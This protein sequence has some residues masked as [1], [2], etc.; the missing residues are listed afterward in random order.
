MNKV[1][2]G[3]LGLAFGLLSLT[4]FSTNAALVEYRG[5]TTAVVNGVGR[6]LTLSL[7][8]DN[9]FPL[10]GPTLQH[11]YDNYP[12]SADIDRYYGYFA[13]YNSSLSLEG[14]AP[15]TGT[16]GDFNIWV[17][18]IDMV[19]GGYDTSTLRLVPEDVVTDWSQHTRFRFLEDSG[20]PFV[21]DSWWGDSPTNDLPPLMELTS[22]D[23]IG[24]G[25]NSEYHSM[26]FQ[27]LLLR[28]VPL[29]AAAWLFGCGL[30]GLLGVVRR[31]TNP[32][33]K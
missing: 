20:E 21:W 27:Q 17:T 16:S 7:T 9:E 26:G 32:A 1:M 19:N 29:P 18:D 6:N 11:M 3:M 4:S 14:V 30:M 13:I 23:V 33:T 22:L 31:S 2:R 8:I 25:A 24:V 28:P 10:Y 5:S 12:S 15:V